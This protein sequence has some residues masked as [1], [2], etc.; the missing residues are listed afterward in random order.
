M[1]PGAGMEGGKIVAQGTPQKI[2]G[3]RDSV[4]G[5][6]L[7]GEA[8]RETACGSA[9]PESPPATEWLVVSGANARNLQG[10]TA[11]FPLGALTC[12]TGV[13]GSGKSSLIVETLTP[14]VARALAER[15]R[16]GRGLAT[17]TEQ[18]GASLVELPGGQPGIS[19]FDSIE[20]LVPIDQSPLGRNARS[21]PATASGVW[22]AIRRLFARTRDARVRGFHASRFSFNAAGGRCPLCR[23]LGTRRIS[24]H[25]LPGVEVTCPECRGARFDRQTLEVKFRGLSVADALALRIDEAAAFFANFADIRRTLD[26]FLDVGLGYLTLGQPAATLSGGEAQRIRLATELSRA[27]NERT[28]YVLDEPTTGLHAAD[29]RR[30]LHLLRRLVCQGHT[31]I[32]VEHQ[33]DFI[34]QADWVVDLG[35]EGGAAGGQIVAMGT[36]ATVAAAPEGHTARAL[37]G[38]L[39]QTQRSHPL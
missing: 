5:Q 13:S 25:L 30:L 7:R 6:Y 26:T 2:A 34:A 18:A 3:H 4:T 31:V 35:P 21:N 32:V 28:L 8:H 1:G 12:V 17:R 24:L 19:G 10:V 11:R 22:D 27:A 36:P 29:V 9:D 37:A 20:R 33:L 14:L 15:D 23:G 39:S 16:R 38:G